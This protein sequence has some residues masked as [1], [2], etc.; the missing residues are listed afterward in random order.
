MSVPF[1]S[2]TRVSLLPYPSPSYSFK[3]V[4]SLNPPVRFFTAAGPVG[5]LAFSFPRM[6]LF[7]V[8]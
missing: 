6:A 8:P 4:L 5:G 3:A 2:T 1:H 7:A